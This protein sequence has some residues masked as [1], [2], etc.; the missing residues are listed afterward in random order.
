MNF[1]TLVSTVADSHIDD[2][3]R[4]DSTNTETDCVYTGVYLPNVAITLR[5]G[6]TFRERFE[7]P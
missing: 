1:E 3:R 2:W 5:W 6:Q 7:E 4:V